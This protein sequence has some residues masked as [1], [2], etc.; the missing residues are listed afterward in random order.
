MT[1]ETASADAALSL[2][3][4]DHPAL[5][6]DFDGTLIDL[7]PEP[8]LVVVDPGLP[9]LLGEIQARLDGALAVV[10]GRE[11]G[12]I[13][14]LIAPLQVA[15][16]GMHGLERRED[17][18]GRIDRPTPLPA[19][20]HL[21]ARLNANPHVRHGG[22]L[23]EDKGLTISL[24]YRRVPD[25]RP[26]VEDLMR[27]AIADLPELHLVPGKMLVEA[28]PFGDSKGTAIEAFLARAPFAGR[29]PVFL[30]DDVSDEDGFRAVAEAGGIGIKIG[31][32]DTRAPFRLPDIR[33]S[34]AYLSRFLGR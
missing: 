29:T 9:D 1:T 4:P 5:F 7:A 28:K 24:H 2:P 11:L 18:K 21:R 32:G 14:T 16:S 20:S 3:V 15:G 17:P 23:L 8:D 25:L 30:G 13:D 31:T 27:E 22:L 12:D 34:R 10:T 6:L 33:A 26:V 19:I